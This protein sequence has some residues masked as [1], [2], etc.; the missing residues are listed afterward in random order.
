M[1]DLSQAKQIEGYTDYW[2]FSDGMVWSN[3]LY[4]GKRGRFLS[5]REFLNKKSNK[6]YKVVSLCNKESKSGNQFIHVL[7]AK[8][9]LGPRPKGY[10]VDHEDGD[11]L[12]NQ[13]SNLRYGTSSQNNINSPPRK[14]DSS[15]YKGV[16]KRRNLNSIKYEAKCQKQIDGNVS[17]IFHIG[18]FDSEI[19]AAK[20]YDK[21]AYELHGEF[22]WLNFPDDYR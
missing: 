19:E 20:A 16:T 22:A 11:S 6:L 13:I 10:L 15:K 18:T 2:I 21:K 7:L 9:F 4:R 8:A 1:V 14:G 3:K 12:N 17:E 5:Q